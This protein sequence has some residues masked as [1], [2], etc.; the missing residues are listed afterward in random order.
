MNKVR[1]NKT[2]AFEKVGELQE[3]IYTLK[4]HIEKEAE[5][6]KENP[7]DT[8]MAYL[9][10]NSARLSEMLNTLKE[11]SGQVLFFVVNYLKAVNGLSALGKHESISTVTKTPCKGIVSLLI[12][13]RYLVS[14][15]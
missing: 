3:T 15:V 6:L 10:Q 7:D 5:R 2:W 11:R 13:L 14:Q 1:E 4:E 12:V 9:R 8:L